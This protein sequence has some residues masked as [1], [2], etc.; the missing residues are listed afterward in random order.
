MPWYLLTLRHCLCH[1]WNMQEL[2]L[3]RLKGGTMTSITTWFFAT[4]SASSHRDL[5]CIGLYMQFIGEVKCNTYLFRR[6]FCRTVVSIEGDNTASILG[7]IGQPQW[8]F[9]YSFFYTL[10]CIF[11]S[12]V[13]LLYKSRSSFGK[14]VGNFPPMKEFPP[15]DCR[16][17]VSTTHYDKNSI[18][19]YSSAASFIKIKWEC[20]VIS[21]SRVQC[22]PVITP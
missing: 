14:G 10:L 1:Q 11:V 19:C 9:I 6:L 20:T 12:S 17:L 2:W 15:L 16:I 21:E 18:K 8:H 7:T 3:C 5:G 22:L 4:L 13:V